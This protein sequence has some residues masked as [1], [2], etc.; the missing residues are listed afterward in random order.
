MSS[1]LA[2]SPPA[3]AGLTFLAFL[4]A[5]AVLS[6]SNE[7]R[8]IAKRYV[9]PGFMAFA[10]IAACGIGAV[11]NAGPER[12]HDFAACVGAAAAFGVWSGMWWLL[13]RRGTDA[14]PR[15]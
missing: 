14:V 10:L 15:T 11:V 4:A 8:S 5:F 7:L 12:A 3:L 9:L 13:G 1:I 2:I 6:F